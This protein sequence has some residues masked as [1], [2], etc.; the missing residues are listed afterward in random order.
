METALVAATAYV[1]QTGEPLP[2]RGAAASALLPE[3]KVLFLTHFVSFLPEILSLTPIRSLLRE[4][5]NKPKPRP[6]HCD[7]L[8]GGAWA[9]QAEKERQIICQARL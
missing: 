4:P 3:P 7:R 6:R 8:C 9:Q 1:A 2:T 5:T